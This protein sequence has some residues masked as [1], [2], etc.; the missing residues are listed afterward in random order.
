M[1]VI[2]ESHARPKPES[3]D[4][5]RSQDE[6]LVAKIEQ[7]VVLPDTLDRVWDQADLHVQSRT[8]VDPTAAELT[9]WETVVDAAQLGLALFRTAGM[10]EGTTTQCRI[11]HAMR[12]LPATGPNHAARSSAWLQAFWYAIITRD[13]PKMTELCELPIDVLR[14][15][16]A[17]HDDFL[18]HWVATLQAYWL[19]RPELVEELT[20]TFDRSHPDVA[21]IAGREYIQHIAYPPINLFYKFLRKDEEGFHTALLAALELHKQYW[22]A[23]PERAGDI[24]GRVPVAVLAIACLAYDGG[25]PVNVQS[26]YLP[27][28]LLKRSWLGEFEV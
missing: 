25:I 13:Q 8:L 3:A 23:T 15:A 14:A 11:H 10:A 5:V 6:R 21:V 4:W 27:E 22:T 24:E 17:D 16:G 28:H 1:T 18:Y 12:T 2:V 19:K 20:A 9:T 26:P 7:L